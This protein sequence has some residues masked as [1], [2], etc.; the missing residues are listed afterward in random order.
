MPDAAER[1]LELLTAEHRYNQLAYMFPDEGPYRRELYPMHMAFITAG[2]TTRER[3]FMGGNGVGKTVLGADETA[4]HATG[5]YPDWWTGYQFN[6]AIPIWIGGDTGETVRDITQAKLFG[7]V[8]KDPALLGTGLIPR[9]AIDAESIRYRPNTNR[10]IDFARVKHK[11]GGWSIVSLKSY[12]QGRKAWQGT[13]IPWIWLDEEP[14]LEIYTECVMRGRTV[15]G[16]I[17]LTF[18]PLSGWTDVVDS[19]MKWEQAR[20]EGGSKIMITCGW[21][22]VPHLTEQEKRELLA[23][24]PGY[25]RDARR[26]GTPVAGKGKVYPIDEKEFVVPPIR[27]PDHFRRICGF[28]GGWYNTAAVWLA[29]DKDSDT[30]YLYSEYKRGE[31]EIPVHAAAIKARGLWIPVVGDAAAIN[32]GDGEKILHLYRAQGVRMRLAEKAVDAGIQNLLD[33]MA[34]GRFKVF[35]TCQK[36]LEE[37]R[38]YSYDEQGRIRKQDDHLMDATRYADR[39]IKYATT[40]RTAPVERHEELTFGIYG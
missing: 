7:D 36:W 32:Q 39:G 31:V 33:R 17:G 9:D 15:N 8:A 21:D 37:F 34:T 29:Y 35:S 24:T 20:A 6:S 28:D 23:A 30:E 14:P 26:Y 22:D 4:C 2:A 38:R 40:Q 11:T 16:H 1:L 25:L 18:T 12:E 5:R 3:C 10:A 27:L 19:Y 13:E